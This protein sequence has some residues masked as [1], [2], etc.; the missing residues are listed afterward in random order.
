M[1]LKKNQSLNGG[2]VLPVWGPEYEVRFDLKINSWASDW[3]S[4]FRFS[5]ALSGACCEIGQ[6]IPAMWTA[7]GTNDQLHLTTNIDSTCNQVFQAELGTFKPGVW[8]NFLISQ[9]KDLVRIKIEL[10]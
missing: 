2:R 1:D 4:I 3:A 5:A 8:Y 9:T 6:R 10:K 7:R